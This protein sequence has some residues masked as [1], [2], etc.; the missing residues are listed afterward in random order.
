MNP[1]TFLIYGLIAGLLAGLV[2]FGAAVVYGEPPIDDAIAI[3]EAAE[4][5]DHSHDETAA[6][7]DEAADH[8]HGD[9]EGVTRGQQAGPGLATATLLMGAVFGGLVGVLSAFA[10]GRLGTLLPAASTAVVGSLAFVSFAV[11][12]WVKFPPNPPAVGDGDTIGERTA[13]YFGF[14]AL[15]IAFVV[16]AVVVA[17]KLLD[18]QPAVIAVA[19][20]GALFVVLILTTGH[21]FPAIDEVPADFDPNVLFSFRVGALATQTALWGTLTVVLTL[22]VDRAFRRETAR[23]GLADSIGTTR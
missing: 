18:R 22:L 21:I 12:P 15:S 5:T 13:L 14:V 6:A 2:A 9:E 20:G 4:D 11:V 7:E 3:E 23:R 10:V 19:A 17:R 1:R 16:I 8:S